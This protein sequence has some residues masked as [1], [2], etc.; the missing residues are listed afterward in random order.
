VHRPVHEEL[1]DGGAH[2]TALAATATA[3]VAATMT[4]RARAEAG[5]TG[6]ETAAEAG[7][8]SL[9]EPGTEVATSGVLAEVVAEF[10]PSLTSMFVQSS[11]VVRAEP[12]TETGPALERP[13]WRCEWG[14]HRLCFLRWQET[15]NALP[16]LERYIGNYRDATFTSGFSGSR[17]A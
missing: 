8:E 7:A 2:V 3:S 10:A 17:R 5:A 6:T 16:M 14:V 9:A 11:T 13:F 12:E 1:E 15:P 4:A